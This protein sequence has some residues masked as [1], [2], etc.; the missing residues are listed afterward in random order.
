VRFF[1][2]AFSGQTAAITFNIVAGRGFAIQSY[3]STVIMHLHTASIQLSLLLEE[4][5]PH[6][7]PQN[8]LTGI[9]GCH[10]R[11]LRAYSLDS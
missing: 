7:D 4:A 6:I 9:L 11:W 8:W 3:S 10:W 1:G 2:I 5:K